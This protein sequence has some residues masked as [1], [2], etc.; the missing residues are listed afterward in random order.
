MFPFGD[1][2]NEAPLLRYL[3]KFYKD[4][5]SW[6]YE[7]YLLKVDR[8]DRISFLTSSLVLSWFFMVEN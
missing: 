4:I 3:I 8:I 5:Y 2:Y 1:H 6:I 7:I